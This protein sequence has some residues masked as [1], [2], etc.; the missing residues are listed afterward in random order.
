[1]TAAPKEIVARRLLKQAEWC[2]RMGSRLYSTLLREAA[3]DVRASGVCCDVLNDHYDDPPD[4]AL[5]L[6][7]LGAVHRLVLQKRAPHLA[8]CYPSA[9][10]RSDCDEL[11]PAFHAA[12]REH[13]ATL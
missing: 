7:F 13:A 9:G 10:G 5:G 1:M 2:E 12:V 3:A 8:A 4:S 11:W 6:R